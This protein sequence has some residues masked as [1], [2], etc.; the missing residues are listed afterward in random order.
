MCF[1]TE[2]CPRMVYAEC[3]LAFDMVSA[4]FIRAFVG[5]EKTVRKVFLG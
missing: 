2:S 4:I 5:R 1:V 3:H